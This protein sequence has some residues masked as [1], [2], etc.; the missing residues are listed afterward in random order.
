LPYKKTP[1][2]VKSLCRAYTEKAVRRLA[3]FAFNPPKD[4]PPGVSVQ[5]AQILLDRGWGRAPQP[6]VGA[7]GK[8]IVITI[9][10]D[11]GKN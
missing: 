4:T 9:R 1:I 5:A 3:L 8:D 6:L 7:E 10:N 2:D 11:D